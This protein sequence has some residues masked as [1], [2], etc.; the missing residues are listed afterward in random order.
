MRYAN[1][2][3]GPSLTARAQLWFASIYGKVPPV[4]PWT[5]SKE[6]GGVYT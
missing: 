1:I 4:P 5:P 6:G 2:V 3:S